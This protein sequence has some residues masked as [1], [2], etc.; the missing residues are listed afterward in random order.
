M[1][2]YFVVIKRHQIFEALKGFH[3]SFNKH[4]YVNDSVKQ[5]YDYTARE[6]VQ[7]MYS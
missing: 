3:G 6:T 2:Y 4:G 5:Y 7:P 1:S